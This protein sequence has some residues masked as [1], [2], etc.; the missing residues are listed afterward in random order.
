[1]INKMEGNLITTKPTS[2]YK[3]SGYTLE[4]LLNSFYQYINECIDLVNS[5][6]ENIKNYSNTF[7]ED[8]KN[9]NLTINSFIEYMRSEGIPTEV[10]NKIN[11]LY[12]NG[13]LTNIINDLC[14]NVNG[15]LTQFEEQLNVNTTNSTLALSKSENPLLT[16]REKGYKIEETDLSTSLVSKITGETPITDNSKGLN[17]NLGVDYPLKS[18]TRNGEMTPINDKLKNGILDIKV[19]G[20]KEGKYYRIQYIGNGITAWGEPYYGCVIYEHDKSTFATDSA[21]SIKPIITRTE[22]AKTPS[23]GITTWLFS[24]P[25]ENIN[26][27]ITLDLSVFGDK[28]N[29]DDKSLGYSSIID[30]SCY[31]MSTTKP[32]Y[33]N[34]NRGVIYPFKNVERNGILGRDL[35]TDLKNGILD[36]K[37]LNAKKDKIYKIDWIGNGT[38]AWGNAEYAI[39]LQEMNEDFTDIKQIFQRQNAHLDAPKNQIETRVIT[40]NST[41]IVLIVTLDYSELKSLS[42]TMNIEGSMGYSCIIDKTCYYVTKDLQNQTTQQFKGLSL[43]KNKNNY[44]IKSSYDENYNIIWEFDSLGINEILHLRKIYFQD[45]T[46]INFS[47]LIDFQTIGTDWISPYNFSAL[48]NIVNNTNITTG[49]NHGTNSGSGFRTSYPKFR[50]CFIDNKEVVNDGQYDNIDKI[51]LKTSN[52]VASSNV[53]NMDTGEG[54]RG[55]ITENV[56]YTITENNIN[57]FVDILINENVLFRTYAGPQISGLATPYKNISFGGDL[58]PK[59]F[60]TFP[61]S[62]RTSSKD[63]GAFVDRFICEHDKGYVVAYKDKNCG[64]NNLQY[65]NNSTGIGQ[66]S[67]S[68]AYLKNFENK[69][70]EFKKGDSFYYNCTYSFN[71][72]YKCNDSL[73]AYKV[74]DLYIVDFDKP[75]TTFFEVESNDINKKVEVIESSNI[76]IGEYSTNLGVKIKSNGIGFVK[77]KLV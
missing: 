77:F 60:D 32:S 57:V 52:D 7:I 44:M 58:N 4:E 12:D 66:I 14:D 35:P 53:I 50:K 15:K 59:I 48:D 41:D 67:G 6:E 68:K 36:V 54:F 5:N 25:N 76:T 63:D 11:E 64:I 71:K 28:V 62:Y 13:T 73:R 3:L 51:V 20:A 37:I 31:V 74:N 45:K 65:V 69:P 27:T 56:T 39:Y 29:L 21:S 1:M 33:L 47:N 9:Q 23:T 40:N 43:L 49:G 22:H 16:L 2:V 24:N 19:I 18:V 75:T 70:T 61:L 72:K 30:E 17:K 34:L 8:I 38:T 26:V 46:S 55:V 10:R 42:Y